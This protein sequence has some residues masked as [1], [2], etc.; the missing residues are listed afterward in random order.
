MFN[1]LQFYFL[2]SLVT[3]QALLPLLPSITSLSYSLR[4][5]FFHNFCL[6]SIL[7]IPISIFYLSW[8]YFGLLLHLR[9]KCLECRLGFNQPKC[10][11]FIIP[12]SGIIIEPIKDVYFMSVMHFGISYTRNLFILDITM[13]QFLLLKKKNSCGKKMAQ[14]LESMCYRC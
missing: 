14:G 11:A 5:Q 1:L 3:L 12:M 2:L 8:I 9:I 4:P 6:T 7:Q 13:N 10:L